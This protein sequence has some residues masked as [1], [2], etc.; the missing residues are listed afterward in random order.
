M[1]EGY[2]GHNKVPT[3]AS[4]RD[5]Q[6]H[7]KEEAE[8]RNDELEKQQFDEELERRQQ[9][10]QE[11]GEDVRLAEHSGAAPAPPTKSG[12]IKADR[13]HVGSHTHKD[14]EK[15]EGQKEKE[16][17]MNRMAPPK[18]E[19]PSDKVNKQ[20]RRTVTDP[21]TGMPVTIEAGD[22]L[23]QQTMKMYDV[24]NSDPEAVGDSPATH[25]PKL[26]KSAQDGGGIDEK[27][28]S[29]APAKPGNILFQPFPAPVEPASAAGYKGALDKAS[30]GVCAGLGLVWIFTAFGSGILRLLFRSFLIG[31]L[32][33]GVV[34]LNGLTKKNIEHSIERVR[35]DM[36]RKRGEKHSPPV[37]ESVEYLNALL[38]TIWR[39]INPEMFVSTID[40][41][42]DVMQASLPG[43]IDAVKISDYGQGSNPVRIISMRGLPDRTT[44][45]DYPKEEWIDQ[46]EKQTKKDADERDKLSKTTEEQDMDEAGDYVNLEIAVAYQARPGQNLKQHN[47]HLLLEFFIGFYDWFNI[48]IPIWAQVEGFAATVRL[49]MQMVP[50]AP[51]IRN[52]TFTLM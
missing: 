48:P 40:M 33:I 19:K 5:E 11:Q 24:A 31:T 18:R 14:K 45:K 36:H 52:L 16:E 7:L 1:G 6:A 22:K 10:K 28:T 51:F 13:P 38:S 25:R 37:P 21:V 23:G 2:S 8:K 15:S 49:R 50:D 3:V 35:L 39:L 42:E 41:V 43:I 9:M 34:M 29:P 27:D 30:A 17:L 20:G 12:T 32:A 4:F 26:N 44:D 47:I 46:G